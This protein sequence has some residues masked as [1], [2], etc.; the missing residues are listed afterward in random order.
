MLEKHVSQQ[1]PFYVLWDGSEARVTAL[2]A[3]TDKELWESGIEVNR[4]IRM[5]V[6][7]EEHVRYYPEH[8]GRGTE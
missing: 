2:R 3:G 4:L 6:A 1:H 7:F 5:L 8:D